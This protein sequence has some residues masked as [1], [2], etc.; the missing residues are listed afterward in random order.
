MAIWGK[1][2]ANLAGE[3]LFANLELQELRRPRLQHALSQPP[4]AEARHKNV[5][6][7]KP[8]SV[9]GPAQSAAV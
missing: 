1:Q 8:A 6:W 3:D 9:Q 5:T 7:G 4:G 2:A